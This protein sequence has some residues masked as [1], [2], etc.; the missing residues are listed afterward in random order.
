MA[1]KVEK[2]EMYRTSDGNDYPET[3]RTSDGNYYPELADALTAERRYWLVE[4]LTD[5]DNGTHWREAGPSDVADVLIANAEEVIAAL[6]P[7]TEED[8]FFCFDK[9]LA[10]SARVGGVPVALP[11]VGKRRSF[12]VTS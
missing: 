2:I 10:G 1:I 4:L 12:D 11:K 6:R 9:D 3:Y 7:E 5:D 8:K